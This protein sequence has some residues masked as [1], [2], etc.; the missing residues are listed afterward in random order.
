MFELK[1]VD[2]DMHENASSM[3]LAFSMNYNIMEAVGTNAFLMV[4]RWYVLSKDSL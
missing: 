3:D 1:S 4:A 2:K